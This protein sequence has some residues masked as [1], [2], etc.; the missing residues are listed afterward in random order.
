MNKGTKESCKVRINGVYYVVADEKAKSKMRTTG[1][2][3]I[4]P[5]FSTEKKATWVSNSVAYEIFSYQS[6]DLDL[7]KYMKLPE[8]EETLEHGLLL[9][10]K[11]PETIHITFEDGSVITLKFLTTEI[12]KKH[13]KD[14]VTAGNSLHFSS[15]S[16][17]Q[18]FYLENDFEPM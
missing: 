1:P 16:E 3:A 7:D 11:V 6:V 5:T 13:L 15:D 9:C 12:F 18:K 8:T 4:S 10:K 2:V 17:L 14:N